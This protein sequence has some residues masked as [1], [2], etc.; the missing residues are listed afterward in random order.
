[1]LDADLPYPVLAM[2]PSLHVSDGAATLNLL[3]CSFDATA[4]HAIRAHLNHQSHL[5]PSR[6]W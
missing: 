6:T 5:C 4:S 1:M 2:L 3:P